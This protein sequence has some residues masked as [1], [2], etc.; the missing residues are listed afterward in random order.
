VA[1]GGRVQPYASSHWKWRQ[2]TSVFA[3]SCRF[4][5]VTDIRG[6]CNCVAPRLMVTASSVSGH[7]RAKHLIAQDHTAA[8]RVLSPHET[9]PSRRAARRFP[10][11]RRHPVDSL[12]LTGC[13]WQGR[14]VGRFKPYQ[15]ASTSGAGHLIEAGRVRFGDGTQVADLCGPV[16]ERV[17]AGIDMSR[18]PGDGL[19]AVK[20][21][22]DAAGASERHR[23]QDLRPVVGFRGRDC[24]LQRNAA[25]SGDERGHADKPNTIFRGLKDHLAGG[26]PRQ[27]FS[28]RR[29][30]HV[31]PSQ[32]W[33]SALGYR[34]CATDLNIKSS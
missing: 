31:P 4:R 17:A 19:A 9:Q 11:R 2:V 21:R 10:I 5:I 27:Y 6:R 24:R 16:R 18:S 8:T 32:Y 22:G 12:S 13:P 15:P 28:P 23:G 26:N 1:A 34:P 7:V 3:S 33:R 14:A 29:V 30:H 20:R 25:R